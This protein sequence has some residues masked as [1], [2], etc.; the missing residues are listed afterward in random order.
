MGGLGWGV[1]VTDSL[2]RRLGEFKAGQTATRH[3]VNGVPRDWAR[4][5]E[6]SRS[7]IASRRFTI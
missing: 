4:D 3:L 1:S 2:A 7:Y 5:P 6:A